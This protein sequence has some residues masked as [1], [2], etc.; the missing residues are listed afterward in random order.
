[1]IGS[2]SSME[3]GCGIAE[4]RGVVDVVCT[5]DMVND[6]KGTDTVGDACDGVLSMKGLWR[7]TNGVE[8]LWLG[9]ERPSTNEA[10]PRR[11]LC[12]SSGRE[13]LILIGLPE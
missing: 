3:E 10:L 7:G 12:G 2:D 6:A 13:E 9:G 8:P 4:R 5:M 11:R 1:M